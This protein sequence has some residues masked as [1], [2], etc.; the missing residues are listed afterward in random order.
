MLQKLTELEKWHR[1]DDPWEYEKCPDDAKRKSVLL[2]EIPQRHFSNVLD[3]GC[4]Q[5]FVTRDLPGDR[6]TGVDVS[7]EAIRKAKSFET[8][9][10]HFLH[11]SLFDLPRNLSGTY[12]LIIICGVLYPQYI[13]KS[14]SLIYQIIEGLL[15]PSGLLVSVHIDEWYS[16]RFPLL[17]TRQYFYEYRDYTH[18]LEIYVK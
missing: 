15:A 9:R 1:K 4:G 7:Q 18:R 14:H 11:S 12:D 10:L 8:E 17:M 6:V 5:G 3:I 13:G 2:S 16:A